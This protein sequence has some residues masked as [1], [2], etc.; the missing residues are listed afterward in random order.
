[1]YALGTE[2]QNRVVREFE[3]ALLMPVALVDFDHFKGRRVCQC[4]GEKAELENRIQKV[5]A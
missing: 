1:M 3:N 2:V 4:L 5:V